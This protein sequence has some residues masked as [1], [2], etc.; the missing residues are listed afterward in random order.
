MNAAAQKANNGVRPMQFAEIV[1]GRRSIKKYDPKH[2][3][4]D[5]ELKTLFERVILSPSS[6]N[7]QHG[8]FVV[9]RD[10]S[11]K[12]K[13]RKAAYDQEQVE[14]ASATIVIVAKLTAHKDAPRIYADAPQPVR[15]AMLPMI[16]GFYAG[17]VT[18]QRDE[19]IR[20]ASL[21]AMTLMY[22]AY[23]VGY[24]TGPMIGFDPQAVSELI[25]LDNEHIPVMLLVIGKQV[26]DVRP[27]AYRHPVAEVVKLES[28]HGKWLT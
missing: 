17:N 9:I 22:A 6:F 14:N 4:T 7:L 1:A 16:E 24:A 2:A 10:K 23:D 28:F 19:A 25:G 3:I 12:S 18:M 26:G 20:S 8:R 27:R 15:D 5:A 13:L 11:V 21:A